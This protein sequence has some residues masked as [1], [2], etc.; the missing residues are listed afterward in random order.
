MTA[1]YYP[2]QQ[3]LTNLSTSKQNVTLSF[4]QIEKIINASLPSIGVHPSRL[5]VK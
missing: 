5:V 3:Y 4:L 1:K 2:L